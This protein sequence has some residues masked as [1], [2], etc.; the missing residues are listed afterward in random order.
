MWLEF[1]LEL[2]EYVYPAEP[3]HGLSQELYGEFG[4]MG[5]KGDHSNVLT[6]GYG[7]SQIISKARFLPGF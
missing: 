2:G 4:K 5:L 3:P 7:I 6:V 1:G